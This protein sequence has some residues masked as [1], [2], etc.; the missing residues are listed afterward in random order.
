M[1]DF[2]DKSHNPCPYIVSCI[3]YGQ[4]AFFCAV[5]LRKDFANNLFSLIFKKCAVQNA[6][7]EMD[8]DRGTCK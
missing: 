6:T 7:G 8:T 4:R 3:L 5:L 1:A 2:F